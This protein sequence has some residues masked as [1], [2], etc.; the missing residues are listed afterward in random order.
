ME[1]DKEKERRDKI[2]Q[3]IGTFYNK[4]ATGQIIELFINPLEEQIHLLETSVK[5]A[6]SYKEEIEKR[7]DESLEALRKQI[8]EKD[9]EI[10]RLR[11]ALGSTFD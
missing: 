2:S 11:S 8:I 5:S 6:N 4:Y 10:K 7:F 3:I 1:Q 9:E